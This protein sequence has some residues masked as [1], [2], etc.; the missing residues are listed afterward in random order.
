MPSANSEDNNE[1][2]VS[3]LYKLVIDFI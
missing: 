2:L 1:A 3:F